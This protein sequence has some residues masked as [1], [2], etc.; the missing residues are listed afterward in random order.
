MDDIRIVIYSCWGRNEDTQCASGC[1][2]GY[3][4]HKQADDLLVDEFLRTQTELCMTYKSGLQQDGKI[5]TI[6]I[7]IVIVIVLIITYALN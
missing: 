7:V 6:V 3:A 1:I 4:R 5:L 2:T